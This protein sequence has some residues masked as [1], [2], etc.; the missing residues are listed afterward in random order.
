MK[1]TTS[2]LNFYSLV[3]TAFGYGNNLVIRPPQHLKVFRA[4]FYADNRNDTINGTAV[5]IS[6]SEILDQETGIFLL[7]TFNTS[8]TVVVPPGIN[9]GQGVVNLYSVV[10][11]R[12]GEGY[13]VDDFFVAGKGGLSVIW[14]GILEN[15][16]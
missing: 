3:G 16:E 10:F 11:D 2:V 9:T 14:E 7:T 12:R 5:Q 6:N 4:T 1:Q 8:T 13:M 15:N